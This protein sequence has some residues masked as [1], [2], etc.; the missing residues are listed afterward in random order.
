MWKP[1]HARL[2]DAFNSKSP[3]L[4][5]R[6]F[7]VFGWI[8]QFQRDK[9]HDGIFLHDNFHIQPFVLFY[10]NSWQRLNLFKT[11]MSPDWRNIWVQFTT[12]GLKF[13]IILICLFLLVW[14]LRTC[15]FHHL[16]LCL[17]NAPYWKN[18][19]MNSFFPIWH[20]SNDMF[21]HPLCWRHHLLVYWWI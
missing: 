4:V 19:H 3:C 21:L 14:S 10:G 18:M 11:Y 12:L 17:I 9:W 5:W 7:S 20:I 8:S 1:R 2:R 6:I 15:S 16:L 13:L